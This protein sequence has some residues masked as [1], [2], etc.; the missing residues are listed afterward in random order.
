MKILK[1]LLFQK[2]IDVYNTNLIIK[3]DNYDF[4]Y[5]VDDEVRIIKNINKYIYNKDSICYAILIYF[6][7]NNYSIEESIKLTNKVMIESLNELDLILDIPDYSIIEK[8]KK[9]YDEY[10]NNNLNN[11]NI[12]TNQPN[13]EILENTNNENINAVKLHNPNDNIEK[14]NIEHQSESEN[15]SN[16]IEVNGGNNE[17]L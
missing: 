1:E 11:I 4:L 14:L 12:E 9:E 8:V 2:F 17:V 15:K 6:L 5:C 13:I 10:K 7:I 3:L 16:Q